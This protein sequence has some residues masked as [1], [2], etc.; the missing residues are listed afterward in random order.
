MVR[1]SIKIEKLRG[2]DQ[3]WG[4]TT[5]LEENYQARKQRIDSLTSKQRSKSTKGRIK[6][7]RPRPGLKRKEYALTSV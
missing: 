1:L 4:L 3:Q 2:K 6:T 5:V 7:K